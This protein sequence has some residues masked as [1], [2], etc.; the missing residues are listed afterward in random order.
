MYYTA[1]NIPVN[2][3]INACLFLRE[4]QKQCFIISNYR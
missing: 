1:Y 4:K 2:K 3:S